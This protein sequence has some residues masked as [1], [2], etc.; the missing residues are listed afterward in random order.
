MK[1]KH[2]TYNHAQLQENQL[3]HQDKKWSNARRQNWG[4]H[5]STAKAKREPN[6]IDQQSAN[7]FDHRVWCARIVGRRQE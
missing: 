5:K 3:D 7:L 6:T 2:Q 4:H 1:N